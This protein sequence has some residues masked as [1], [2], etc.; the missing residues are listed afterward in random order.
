MQK[1]EN[2]IKG[3]PSSIS[4]KLYFHAKSGEMRKAEKVNRKRQAHEDKGVGEYT[5]EKKNQLNHHAYC[6]CK[7]KQ[8][9]RPS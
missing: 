7:L 3:N 4:P 1:A 6:N 8:H 9:G 2:K 5:E